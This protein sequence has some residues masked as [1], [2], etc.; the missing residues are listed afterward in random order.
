LA[1]LKATLADIR[2]VFPDAGI[3]TDDLIAG[4]GTVA[5][6]VRFRGTPDAAA[7]GLEDIASQPLEIGGLLYGEIVGGRILEFWAYFDPS[8][9]VDLVGLMAGTAQATPGEASGHGEEPSEHGHDEAVATGSVEAGAEEV[10]VTLTEFSITLARSTLRAGQ[11]YAFAVTNEGAAPHEFVIE[12]PG[13]TH[14]PLEDEDQTAMVTGIAPGETRT[15]GWTF[16]EPGSYQL[17]CHQPGH[18]EAG[19]V[20]VVEV[21]A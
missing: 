15:L 5:A 17:A 3:A 6:R 18:Y 10:A 11:P 7:L 2:R 14:E 20:L 12:R 8:A 16:A 21:T 19:Q 1:G 13:A 4:G 9:Y